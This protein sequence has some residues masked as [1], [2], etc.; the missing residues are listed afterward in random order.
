MFAECLS[1]SLKSHAVAGCFSLSPIFAGCRSLSL[2]SHGVT[3]CLSLFPM[4]AGYLSLSLLVPWSCCISLTFSYVHWVS[5]T[6]CSSAME[7]HHVSPSAMVSGLLSL[8][9]RSHGVGTCLSFSLPVPCSCCMSL[10]VYDGCWP[11]LTVYQISWSCFMS[12]TVSY[13]L[14]L[15]L[16]VSPN[17]MKLLHVSYGILWLLAFSHCLSRPMEFLHVSHCLFRFMEF[18]HV[19]HFSHFCWLSLQVQSNFCM[20]PTIAGFLFLS[21]RSHGVATCL[22]LSLTCAGCLS[23]FLLVPWSCCTSLTL[24][25]VCLHTLIVRL[26]AI[27]FSHDSLMI[28]GC[29]LLSLQS[30]RVTTCLL[31]SPIVAGF[32]SL[33]LQ[34]NSVAA[35]LSL[36]SM[37]AGCL[38][39][40][41]GS[42]R[43][44]ACRSLSPMYT[45]CF[46]LSL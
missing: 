26:S 6:V 3:A 40:S 43:V 23:L 30:N 22:S 19:S 14:W 39:M 46:S 10:T 7:L 2:K 25:Y 45:G 16:T 34:S 44:A 17:A 35:C 31:M 15:F 37:V 9:L 28:T 11:S 33:S 5:L 13:A 1:M 24:F 20:S 32:L 12:L 21:L 29:L 38:S 36:S 27:E 42:N 8:S 18:L 4:V 41:L